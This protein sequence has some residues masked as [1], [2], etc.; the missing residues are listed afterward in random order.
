MA[1]VETDIFDSPLRFRALIFLFTPLIDIAI[2]YLHAVRYFAGV[3]HHSYCYFMQKF[4]S[5]F[6][7][8]SRFHVI[9]L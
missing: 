3:F 2:V 1:C 8:S 6:T 4:I 5:M 9:I 7:W